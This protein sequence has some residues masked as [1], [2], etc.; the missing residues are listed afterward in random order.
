MP[1]LEAVKMWSELGL[2][3][4]FGAKAARKTVRDKVSL[5]CKMESL[6]ESSSQF[7]QSICSTP[8]FARFSTPLFSGS[9]RTEF[10][11]KFEEN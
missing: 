5:S 11:R 7:V 8:I 6:Y 10:E 2:G 4:G 3:L 9:H 1:S